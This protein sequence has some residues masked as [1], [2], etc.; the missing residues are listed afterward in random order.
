MGKEKVRGFF[1][2]CRLRDLGAEVLRAAAAKFS[3]SRAGGLS[4]FG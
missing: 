3:A 1:Y 4:D 2:S